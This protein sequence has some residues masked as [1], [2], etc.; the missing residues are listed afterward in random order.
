MGDEA[1]LNAPAVPVGDAI[2]IH[3]RVFR[4]IPGTTTKSGK[5]R[6]MSAKDRKF[7]SERAG[8]IFDTIF[9]W[10]VN[11]PKSFQ[12]RNKVILEKRTLDKVREIHY[13]EAGRIGAETVLKRYRNMSF[14][15]R[16]RCAF[17][18]RID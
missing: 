1:K 4:M 7:Y 15:S 11:R 8:K 14:W 16:I 10:I 17:T 6:R 9:D 3:T 2:D 12:M 5:I 18:G 13:K